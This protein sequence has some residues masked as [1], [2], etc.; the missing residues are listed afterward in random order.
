MGFLEGVTVIEISENIS[1]SACTK[2]MAALGAEVIKIEPPGDGDTTRRMGPFPSDEPHPEKSGLFL[3]LNT[4]KKSVT[5]DLEKKEGREILAE[6]LKKVHLL[7]EDLEIGRKKKFKISYRKIEKEFP[8]L[9][10]TS[11]TPFG[12]SGPY[13]RYKAEAIITE[14]ASGM[15]LQHGSPEREPLKMGGHVIYYRAA[16]SAFCGSIAALIYAEATG[17]GQKVE[18]SIQEVLLHDDFITIEAFLCRGE[19]IRRRFAPM[20]LPCEDGWFYI[21]AFPHE[22]PRLC[23]ALGIE[24]LEKDERFLDM[25]KRA[26]NAETLNQIVLNKLGNLKKEEIYHLLQKNRIS[27]AYLASVEDV[28][29]SEHYRTRGFFVTIDHP[30]AGALEYP[31]SFASTDDVEWIHSRAPLLGEHTVEILENRLGYDK[32]SIVRLRQL[33]VI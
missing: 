8:H 20:L 4:G 10:Y 3:Y 6:L 26:E 29:W 19:E 9:V 32:S 24:E 33:G 16:A 2:W 30:F 23:K 17:M 18:V 12:E 28:F 1:A 27:A 14:A 31:G 7:I 22:W 13:S 5:L 25:Q 21:R 15:L 11:I